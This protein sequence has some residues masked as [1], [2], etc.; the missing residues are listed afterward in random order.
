M[1]SEYGGVWHRGEIA[2]Q[3]RAGTLESS[4]RAAPFIR[5][6]MPDQHRAFFAQLPFMV[7]GGVDPE[8]A[9]WASILE[10]WRGFITSPD[11]EHLELAAHPAP[12]DPL[13]TCLATGH[14]IGMLGIEPATRR[15]N[16]LN[17]IVEAADPVLRVRVQH[18]FGNCPQYIQARSFA[19]RRVVGEEQ[20]VWLDA[21]DDDLR[22][23]IAAADTFF[24][25][26]YIDKGA[27]RQVD[28]S[29]RGGRPGF[30]MVGDDGTLTI[31]DFGGNGFFMTLGNLIVNPRAGLV[32]IDYRD[33]TVVQMTGRGE[34]GPED[35]A[36]PWG[37]VPGAQ[38]YWRF[39][40]ER[41]VRRTPGVRLLGCFESWSD[42]ARAHGTWR[43]AE[44]GLRAGRVG[45]GWRSLKVVEAIDEAPGIRSLVLADADGNGLI[46]PLPGQHL[47]LRLALVEGGALQRT[48]TISGFERGRGYR[49]T[50]RRQ[51]R[52][53]ELL[54]QRVGVGDLIETLPPAGQFVFDP[55]AAERAVLIAG[56]IGVTPF[57]AM[58]RAAAEGFEQ[59]GW[60]RFIALTV[61]VR[62]VAAA[63]FVQELA[64]LVDRSGGHLQVTL[65]SPD[66]S[67]ELPD[68]LLHVRG[69]L[70]P[71]AVAKLADPAGTEHFLCGPPGFMQDIYAGLRAA[72]VRDGAIMAEG[73]GPSALTRSPDPG[74]RCRALP[75]AS[76]KPVLVRFGPG[77]HWVKWSSG[78]L[79]E[80]AERSGLA[81]PASCRGGNCGSCRAR[82]IS[83]VVT[84][85]AEPAYRPQHGEVLP[86]VAHP[87]DG[88]GPIELAWG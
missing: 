78:S 22:A 60:M 59:T 51:G 19:S 44:D 63:P 15:R 17:A 21:I 74:R 12:G 62:S 88:S 10:G 58:L 49:L 47:P 32:F 24:V 39:F 13:A 18:S 8:G 38:R 42:E 67:H 86:C 87:A 28:V 23:M 14:A 20:V 2:M 56:G 52:V 84:Y 65:V 46:A 79:L 26:T 9:A 73:F 33:G 61:A 77:E 71:P 48:Y 69:R 81:A 50:I 54:H 43:E 76:G 7:L 29:H 27:S 6:F 80:L 31:P 85:A 40:P 11:P 83:G 34:V 25:A 70:D 36:S 16:R 68:P 4:R 64:R 3:A 66:V 82:L 30:V 1:G 57:I 45:P 75:P 55:L 72:G 41:I 35:S 5:S 37:S 53:S